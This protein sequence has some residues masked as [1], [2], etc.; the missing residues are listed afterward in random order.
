MKTA[1]AVCSTVCL[2]DLTRFDEGMA[3]PNVFMEEDSSLLVSQI[4][5]SD[6][7]FGSK[8]DVCSEAQVDAF[9]EWGAG[10]GKRAVLLC[11]KKRSAMSF[12]DY[13]EEVSHSE[14][15]DFS[16]GTV[17]LGRQPSSGEFWFSTQ[18]DVEA[19]PP[20]GR[21][22]RKVINIDQ[23]S[24]NT[25]YSS[26]MVTCGWLFSEMDILDRPGLL[27]V[28][29]AVSQSNKVV[30]LKAICRVGQ[31]EWINISYGRAGNMA[32]EAVN[33]AEIPSFDLG[34][35]RVE[36]IV[37]EAAAQSNLASEVIS[38]DGSSSLAN[39]LLLND[40][41]GVECRLLRLVKR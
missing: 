28:L 17:V 2:V 41:A 23:D 34:N 39:I 35:S 7:V 38:E 15:A 4:E 24:R 13:I 10:L 25:Q 6:V 21:P 32:A 20:P 31:Q 5:V 27:D 33:V 30:R 29:A 26:S 36:I 1:I 9:L 18:V 19:Q 40:W 22:I 3:A 11:D 14:A 37:H 16:C 8:K 12:L